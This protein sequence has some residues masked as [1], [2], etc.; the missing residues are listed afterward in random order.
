MFLRNND[1]ESHFQLTRDLGLNAIRL[2]GKFE[3]DDWFDLADK[4]GILTMPGWSCCDAWE[5]FYVWE[6][7]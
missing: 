6:E 3:D 2:K 5:H 1:F 4:Y 7:E